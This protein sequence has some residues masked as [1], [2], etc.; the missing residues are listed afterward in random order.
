MRNIF[1]YI[2]TSLEH[3]RDFNGWHPKT[4]AVQGSETVLFKHKYITAPTI[5]PADAIVQAA[6]NCKM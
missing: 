1:T 3:Y 5:T 2:G 4:R 6:K